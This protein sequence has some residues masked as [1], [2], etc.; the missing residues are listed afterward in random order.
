MVSRRNLATIFLM[1]LTIFFMFQ[2]T[3]MVKFRNSRFDTN[4]Y[5][6]TPTQTAAGQYYASMSDGYVIYIGDSSTSQYKAVEKWCNNTKVYLVNKTSLNAAG[7]TI[8]EEAEMIFVDGQIDGADDPDKLEVIT[9][10]NTPVVF[11][12]MPDFDAVKSSRKMRKILGIR[13]AKGEEIKALGL[14]FFDGFLIGGE[15][16]YLPQKPEEEKYNDLELTSPWYETGAGTEAY[17]VGMLDETEYKAEDFPRIIWRNTYNGTYV[18]AVSTDIINEE[19]GP[20]II[21]SIAYEAKDYYIYPVINAQNVVLTDFPYVTNENQMEIQRLYSMNSQ[22]LSRDIMWPA[23]LSLATNDK[24]K[25]SC[26]LNP[27][28]AYNQEEKVSKEYLEFYLK[29]LQEV[30]G[31]LGKSIHLD[32]EKSLEEDIAASYDFYKCV[33]RYAYVSAYS[34]EIPVISNEDELSMHTF[35]CKEGDTEVAYLT[36]NSTCQKITNYADEYTYS[37]ALKNRCLL[38]AIGYS[39][40]LIDTSKVLNPQGLEDEWQNF[41][42]EVFGNIDTI[43]CSNDYFDFTATGEAD[44]RI[45]DYLNVKYDSVYE[46][47]KVYLKVENTDEAYFVFRVH[48]EAVK[49]VENGEFKKLEKDTYLIHAYSGNCV[50]SLK[51]AEEILHYQKP[52]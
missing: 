14:Q 11:V 21:S 18:F 31:E 42:K 34:D 24:L 17:A 6:T 49:S 40:T 43:Y 20:G 7:Q 36:E 39:N 38:N 25:L 26:F 29:Q 9:E 27:T 47:G 12:R 16:A 45:R 52:F 48:N 32:E 19:F 1:M 23:I 50:I 44:S 37:K 28:R 13:K 4:E 41:S 51:E 35:I 10:C 46:D 5:A 33:P 30:D 3:Q 8:L 22:S 15:A 2:F